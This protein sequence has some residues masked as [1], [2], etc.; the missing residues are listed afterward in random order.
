MNTA[1]LLEFILKQFSKNLDCD[2]YW[3][4]VSE[5]CRDEK[6]QKLLDTLTFE[7]ILPLENLDIYSYYILNNKQ[8]VLDSKEFIIKHANEIDFVWIT[9]EFIK[10]YNLEPD[11][12]MLNILEIIELYEGEE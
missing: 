7:E 6:F 1:E 9:D 8:K 10:E 2:D 12:D 4:V 11:T 5:M 3:D